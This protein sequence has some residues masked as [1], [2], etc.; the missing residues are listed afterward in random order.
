MIALERFPMNRS[1]D[2]FAFERLLDKVA[3]YIDEVYIDETWFEGAPDEGFGGVPD[4][5]LAAS[6]PMQASM[7]SMQPDDFADDL[8]PVLAEYGTVD[9]FSIDGEITASFAPIELEEPIA[10]PVSDR[11]YASEDGSVS[12]DLAA[13]L[14][15]LDESFARTVMRLIDE[16]GL[17]DADV[18]KRANMSR[19][20]F[21]KIR[22]DEGYR[23]TKKT[24]C[25]LAFALELS[26]DDALALLGRAGFTLSHSSKFDIIVEYFLV[27]RIHDIHQINMALYAFDQQVLG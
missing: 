14:E 22:K 11:A 2:S 15:R 6:M 9:D 27:N 19:Q 10:P 25:A 20:L 21:A 24:A 17:R 7:P 26:H 16:R 12:P 18:Y 8:A 23:P 5:G 4:E 1:G 3:T 13:R